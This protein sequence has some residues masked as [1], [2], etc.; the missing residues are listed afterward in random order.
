MMLLRMSLVVL[1]L[2][3][4]RGVV[5]KT[6]VMCT[7]RVCIYRPLV[8][9]TPYSYWLAPLVAP[10][11]Y[12]MILLS[13]VVLWMDSG[14]IVLSSILYYKEDFVL[15][16]S[17]YTSFPVGGGVPLLQFIERA[18]NSKDGQTDLRGRYGRNTCLDR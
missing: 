9:I 4:L 17:L 3:D 1:D 5:N 15:I 18:L 6:V 13:S 11:S 16:V 2:S 7:T 10:Y 8:L 14:P 12:W